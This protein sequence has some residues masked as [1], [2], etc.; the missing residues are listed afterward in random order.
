MTQKKEYIRYV[1]S[2][3]DIRWDIKVD[4]LVIGAGGCGLV[5]ALAA[6]ERGA[7][8][9]IVEKEKSAGGNPSLSQAMVP[10]TGT[11]MQ[12]AAGIEDSVELMTADILKKNKNGSDPELTAHIAAQSASLIEWLK[13]SMGI[14]LELVSDFIYPGHSAHRIHANRSRKGENLINNLLNAAA[15]FDN[16]DIAYNAPAV[17]LIAASSDSAVLGAEIEIEGIGKNLARAGK[18]FWRSMG[19]APTAK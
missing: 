11:S 13:A 16:L 8:V 14:E 6:A 2:P 9:F 19:S 4:I 3:E 18:T 7:S 10:A 1:E 12:R 15:R 5:A 17:K